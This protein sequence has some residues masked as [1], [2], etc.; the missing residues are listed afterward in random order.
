MLILVI[1]LRRNIGKIMRST[2][3]N[4]QFSISA[5][6]QTNQR[7]EGEG[8]GEGREGSPGF[9]KLYWLLRLKR[10]MFTGEFNLA[11]P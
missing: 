7:R 2:P 1:Y 4:L 9:E 10:R 5:S 8:E 11:Q 6:N 3:S